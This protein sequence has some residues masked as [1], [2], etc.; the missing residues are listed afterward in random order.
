[1]RS[2]RLGPDWAGWLD[3]LPRLAADLVEEWELTLDGPVWHG[4]CS[5]VPAVRTEDGTPAVLKL[6]FDGDEESEHEAPRAPALGRPRDGPAAARRP[7]PP[8]P[9]AGAAG[10]DDL[11][12]VGYVEAAETSAASTPR[13]HVPA[14]PQLRTVHVVRRAAGSTTWP[15]WPRTPRSRGAWSSRRCTSAGPWSATRP[16]P[17]SWCTATCTTTTCSPPTRRAV[18]GHR[19][20]ADVRRPALRAGADAVEPLGGGRRRRRRAPPCAAGSTPWSTPPGSTRSGPATG[21]SCGWWSTRT[22]PSRTGRGPAA[23][24]TGRARLDHP[25]HRDRQGRAGLSDLPSSPR[26]TGSPTLSA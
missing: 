20:Q 16:A 21:W 6:T 1:M 10:R 4:F 15:P 17:A 9:A 5:L 8:G 2:A 3:R 13:L 19:P 11:S 14:P 22:G 24:S 12:T 25:V 23:R 18:A 26:P 7:A